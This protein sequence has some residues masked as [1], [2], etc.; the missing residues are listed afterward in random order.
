V[1]GSF[2]PS[3][4][5]LLK[6]AADR[7]ARD[8]AAGGHELS[9]AGS[10]AC[11]C[12]A[13]AARVE[14]D[15]DRLERAQTFDVGR[16]HMQHRNRFPDQKWTS[17]A[18]LREAIESWM[19][20]PWRDDRG[21]LKRGIWAT[22]AL[23]RLGE[24][25]IPADALIRRGLQRRFRSRL[26]S[27]AVPARADLAVREES[28]AR[29]PV[30]APLMPWIEALAACGDQSVDRDTDAARN[31]PVRLAKALTGEFRT[32]VNSWFEEASIKDIIS[33]R[34]DAEP[35]EGLIEAELTIP[36]GPSA[37]DWVID[38][39]ERTRLHDWREASLLWE[40][41]YLDEPEE[42]AADAGVPLAL[43]EER[44]SHFDLVIQALRRSA[45]YRLVDDPVLGDLSYS[46]LVDQVTA[47]IGD[48]R[49]A[50]VV[51][52][53]DAGVNE[54][55]YHQQL[56][57]MLAFC[58]IPAEPD[59]AL[60]MFDGLSVH[61]TLSDGLLGVNRVAAYLRLGDV[62]AAE[63][64]LAKVLNEARNSEALLW[65]LNRLLDYESTPD[66]LHSTTTHEWASEVLQHLR[67]YRGQD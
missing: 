16:E 11:G 26:T 38:R 4:R 52:L 1:A 19:T 27:L 41:R 15:A 3:D 7:F 48:G 30:A 17:S 35:H 42:T 58:L 24:R 49:L 66:A 45:R 60:T 57:A 22:A 29:P 25:G 50:T 61:G 9:P 53:L 21:S 56:R 43:V 33:W 40:V 54:R 13:L 46:E 2:T 10:E 47:L 28:S 31:L 12:R 34:F 8:C 14:R 44:P 36:G 18:L 20:P 63:G 64:E 62:A 55:P 6:R 59:R 23:A 5:R 37:L 32:I 65:P 39:L 51:E 67:S